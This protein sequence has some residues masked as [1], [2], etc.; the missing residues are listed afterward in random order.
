MGIKG[1]SRHGVLRLNLVFF[2][3]LSLVADVNLC[4]L[5]FYFCRIHNHRHRNCRRRRRDLSYAYLTE[6][7]LR[8]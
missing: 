6:Y 3:G 7:F 4:H 1:D 2:L 8:C 5:C